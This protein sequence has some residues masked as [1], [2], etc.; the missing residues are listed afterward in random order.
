MHDAS[1]AIVIDGKVIAA[2][3]EERFTRV[4][5]T[6]G[7][8]ENAMQFCLDFAGIKI[9]DVDIVCASWRPWALRVRATQALKSLFTS[10]ALFRAKTS[11]GMGQMQNEWAELFR[12]RRTIENHFGKGNYKI[13]F[14]DHHLS[15]AAS[16][17]LS[18]PFE[19]AAVL[20]V[21]GAGE[22]DTT[23][24]WIGDGTSIKKLESIRLPYSLGQFYSAVTA[25]LGFKVQ[26]DE[27]KVMGLAAYGEPVYADYIGKNVIKLLPNGLFKIDPYFVDYHLAR[28]GVF[29]KTAIDV[30]GEP[31]KKE[32]EVTK[33]HMDI[34]ASAQAVVED[35]IFHVVN[36]L[37][38]ITKL[39]KL[40]MAGGVA[41]NCVAN[42]KLFKKTSVKDVFIQPAAGDAGCALG[43]ALYLEHKNTGR[44]RQINLN[45]NAYLGPSFS[46]SDAEKA[47]KD[48]NIPYEK[49]PEDI[50]FSRTAGELADGKLVCWFQ[51]KMEWGPRAL[52]ARSLLADPRRAEMK[53]II[54]EKVKQREQFRP[55]APS[56]L[57]EHAH[58]IFEYYHNSPFMIFTFPVKNSM[59][60]KI[61][62]VVHIDKTARPQA[63]FKETNPGYWN[64]INEFY[65]ITGIPLLLNTSFNVQEPIVCTP[66]DAITTF[67]N[68]KVDYLILEDCMAALPT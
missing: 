37:C 21:D 14:V 24:L 5:H 57:S 27:Y 49:L 13:E 31:R 63:V 18:S 59:A 4:K 23:V 43:S 53:D 47:L 32:E 20:T 52:G 6:R 9:G 8:P 66:M 65:K 54:N 35:A 46:S 50:L 58:E 42:G 10:P 61:P 38:K 34:A 2:A 51:G 36:H 3:E 7:F 44:E 26:S 48:M 68:T 16:A 17:F 25:F 40:C 39:D 1:A 41:F 28:D 62:A 29:R 30:F 60:D 22:A 19:R 64:L 12:F 56:I 55:F 11:R 67:L 15:H 33:R 45:N